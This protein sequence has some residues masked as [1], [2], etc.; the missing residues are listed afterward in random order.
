M[1]T[2]LPLN[3]PIRHNPNKGIQEL[4]HLT[5]NLLF[6]VGEQAIQIEED[7]QPVF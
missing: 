3:R 7:E 6:L 1:E 5:E 2:T 4:L